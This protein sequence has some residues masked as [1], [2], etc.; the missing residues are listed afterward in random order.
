M[1]WI[2]ALIASGGGQII[3]NADQGKDATP[4][5]ASPGRRRGRRRSSVTLARSSGRTAGDVDRR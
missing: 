5:I 3:T 1:V 4:T 2:N